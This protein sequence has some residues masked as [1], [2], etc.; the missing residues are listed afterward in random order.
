[1]PFVFYFF[2]VY[3]LNSFFAI[4]FN[5]F[6]LKLNTKLNVVYSFSS[7]SISYILYLA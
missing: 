3:S 2:Y 5:M 7:S 1:M 6:N 4:I